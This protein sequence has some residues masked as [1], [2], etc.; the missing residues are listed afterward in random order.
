MNLTFGICWIEDQAS[1]AEVQ[2]VEDEIRNCGFEP[3]IH[4]IE[5]EED[6]REFAE[7][8]ERFQDYDLIL[9]DLRLGSDLHGDDIAPEVRRQFRSTPILFYSVEEV[10]ELRK[11]MGAKAVE[12]VYCAHRTGLPARVSELIS[13]LSPWLN[14]LSG[15]RGL[16][17]RVVAQCDEEFR[18]VLFHWATQAER[19]ACLVASVKD[20]VRVTSERQSTETA[21]IDSL[22][23]MLDHRAISSSLLFREV[24]ERIDDWPVANRELQDEIGAT[25]R[26]LRQYEEKVLAVRNSLAHALEERTEGGWKI[27]R[28]PP[29]PD[30]TRNDFESFRSEFR[31]QLRHVR[32]LRELLV[33][34]QAE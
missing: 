28:R 16:A 21:Q 6:I 15:M 23:D 7:R 24:H 2:A 19:E 22:D 13:G 34:Q 10:G 26:E 31:E 14:R 3:E 5:N 4:Q 17:A 12:G 20:R 30:L 8:Q 27:S 25:R 29:N 33:D 18:K 32:R 11:R 1:E 9:L